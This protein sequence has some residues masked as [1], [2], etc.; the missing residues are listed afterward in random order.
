MTTPWNVE[1]AERR[2]NHFHYMRI[3][4]YNGWGEQVARF[5]FK[6]WK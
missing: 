4:L 3:M 6:S 2:K 5:K 1:I